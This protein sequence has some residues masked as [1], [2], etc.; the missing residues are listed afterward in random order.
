MGQF[1][2]PVKDF[3]DVDNVQTSK[4]PSN[5]P[6]AW[7]N[8]DWNLLCCGFDL[9]PHLYIGRSWDAVCVGIPLVIARTFHIMKL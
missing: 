4:S 3:T 1:G 2:T 6:D 8:H 7:F 9:I 5:C